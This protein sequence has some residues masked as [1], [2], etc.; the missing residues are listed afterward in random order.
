MI[1]A[2][3]MMR[4]QRW[5]LTEFTMRVVIRKTRR[6]SMINF[7]RGRQAGRPGQ[8]INDF[9]D[10]RFA[11]FFP[12]L[13]FVGDGDVGAA[14]PPARPRQRVSEVTRKIISH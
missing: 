11:G 14:P 2:T 12:G 4:S 8:F 6:H 9:L 7:W 10:D 3:G 1:S 13:G 5:D